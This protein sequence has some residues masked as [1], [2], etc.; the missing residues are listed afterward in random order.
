ME[1]P[2]AGDRMNIER[3]GIMEKKFLLVEGVFA[4]CSWATL[5]YNGDPDLA[6]CAKYGRI[7]DGW[8]VTGYCRGFGGCDE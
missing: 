1:D 2:H 7:M 8:T 3:S 6:Y 4:Q 5:N